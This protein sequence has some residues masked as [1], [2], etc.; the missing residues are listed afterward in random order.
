M[1]TCPLGKSNPKEHVSV[2]ILKKSTKTRRK[3]LIF[4][5]LTKSACVM[6][7]CYS[8]KKKKIKNN[9]LLTSLPMEHC[10]SFYTL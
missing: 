10:V 6:H 8:F 1:L 2:S 9:F 7:C 3:S 5:D 4:L